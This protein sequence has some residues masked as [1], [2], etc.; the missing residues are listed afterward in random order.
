LGGDIVHRRTI[1]Y[2]V[3]FVGG[4][5]SEKVALYSL[6]RLADSVELD[7]AV[8]EFDREF[9]SESKQV[10]EGIYSTAGEEIVAT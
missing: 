8:V 4:T 6:Q 10:V 5:T 1:P 9:L 2:H 7:I 3:L